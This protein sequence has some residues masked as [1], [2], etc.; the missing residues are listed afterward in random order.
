[1]PLSDSVVYLDHSESGKFDLTDEVIAVIHLGIAVGH[2]REVNAGHR[3]T[4][5]SGFETLPVPERFHNVEPRLRGHYLRGL[6]KNGTDFIFR[7]AVEKLTLPDD[8]PLSAGQTRLCGE[9][10]GGKSL[11]TIGSRT[12]QD[13]FFHH[14]DLPG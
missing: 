1:M 8:I 14:A 7:E 5:R 13:L 12:T 9:H 2:G 10:I 4:E 6:A 3:Q 11:D